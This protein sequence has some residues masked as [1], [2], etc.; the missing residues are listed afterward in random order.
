VGGLHRI[1]SALGGLLATALALALM[2]AVA[3]AL[4]QGFSDRVVYRG[5]DAPTASAVAPHGVRFVGEKDGVIVRYD[6]PGD[7][8]PRM[9][10][11]LSDKVMSA[12][13][14]GLEAIA[15]DPGYPERPYLYVSYTYDGSIGGP[16]PKWG[17]AG[18]GRDDRCLPGDP[19][20]GLPDGG[21]GGHPGAHPVL[22]QP[23]PAAA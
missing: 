2:P 22:P 11:D 21:G 20:P 6:G 5:L 7:T 23:D 1:R 3:D 12:Y 18:S 15:L 4:P 14:R 13:D 17:T 9:V 8:T 16:F 19:D 10:A